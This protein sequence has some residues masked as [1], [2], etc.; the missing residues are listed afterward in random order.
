MRIIPCGRR[1]VGGDGPARDDEAEYWLTRAVE[2][3]QRALDAACPAAR[4]AHL[5]LTTLYR[6]RALSA[7]RDNDRVQDWPGEGMAALPA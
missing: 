5:A 4:A 6:R 7:G 3:S 1:D 2:Q